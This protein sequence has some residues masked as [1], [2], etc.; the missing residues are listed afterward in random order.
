VRHCEKV[1]APV[2]L[3][4]ATTRPLKPKSRKA[5]R[6]VALLVSLAEATTSA[7]AA[8]PAAATTSAPTTAATSAPMGGSCLSTRE[9]V[10]APVLTA[11][12]RTRPSKNAA[13][14]PAAY[15][16][17]Y[18]PLVRPPVQEKPWMRWTYARRDHRPCG[19]RAATPQPNGRRQ[20]RRRCRG[21]PSRG[22][23]HAAANGTCSRPDPR[24]RSPPPPQGW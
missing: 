5:R 15:N 14:A 18:R 23:G 1:L 2:F 7:T 8:S 9:E 19:G 24:T 6:Q 16:V 20:R 21:H 13:T 3:R 12:V 22:T 17:L 10:L 4:G 11:G